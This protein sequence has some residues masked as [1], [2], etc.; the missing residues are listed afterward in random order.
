MSLPASQKL[1]LLRQSVLAAAGL[2]GNVDV[3]IE[4][5][6]D[7]TVIRV[8]GRRI[9]VTSPLRWKLYRWGWQARLDRIAREYGIGRHVVLKPG[10]AVVDIGANVGEFALLAAGS[11]ARVFCCEPDPAALTC[12]R[13]N[14]AGVAGITVIETAIWKEDG[15]VTFGLA[16]ERADSSIFE[17]GAGIERVT[18]PALTLA[19]L[20]A[21][22]K[23][24]EVAF[25][26]CDAEGAEPEVLEG[27]GERLR[28]VRAVAFDTGPERAGE[29]THDAC[30]AILERHGFRVV[31]EKVGTRWMTYGINRQL[32]P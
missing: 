18:R 16:P 27:A 1:K 26:K 24:E 29:R 23:L 28:S 25:I 31:E 7:G 21:R 10:D 6:A 19:T 30:A 32:A 4:Q 17:Q 20:F 8:D 9:H 15:T 5:G 22:E 12:L 14:I 11:G 13:R 2:G 3:A